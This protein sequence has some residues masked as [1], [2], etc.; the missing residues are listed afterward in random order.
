M[1]KT[2][3]II[4]PAVL[5]SSLTGGLDTFNLG[6]IVQFDDKNNP[7]WSTMWDPKPRNTNNDL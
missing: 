6:Y 7:I 1:G 4:K 2:T 3:A 5:D